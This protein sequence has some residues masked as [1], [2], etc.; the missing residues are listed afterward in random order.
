MSSSE[1]SLPNLTPIQT[2]LDSISPVVLLILNAISGLECEA[3]GN[4]AGM[5][6]CGID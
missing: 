2:D 1:E 6:P 4:L 3:Q 5:D